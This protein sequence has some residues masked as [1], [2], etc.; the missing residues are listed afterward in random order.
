MHACSL[1]TA[2]PV[3]YMQPWHAWLSTYWH[4]SDCATTGFMDMQV[5]C[6]R[7][8]NKGQEFQPWLF[9][10]SGN[11]SPAVL[12]IVKNSLLFDT[13]NAAQYDDHIGNQQD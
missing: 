1:N 13:A 12:F 11:I 10:T 8:N 7:V 6:Y 3:L 2:M 5:R 9:N 4:Q